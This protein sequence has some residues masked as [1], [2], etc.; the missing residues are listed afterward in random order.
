MANHTPNALGMTLWSG[1]TRIQDYVFNHKDGSKFWRMF[2][3][4]F[5][6]RKI[7][8]V[9]CH[10]ILP[11][12]LW[13]KNTLLRRTPS[14]GTQKCLFAMWL[15]KPKR[16]ILKSMPALSAWWNINSA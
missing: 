11:R 13:Y 4:P 10:P 3:A 12:T 16:V 6:V 9:W 1:E 14:I 15:A 8:G 7:F 5:I 2:A